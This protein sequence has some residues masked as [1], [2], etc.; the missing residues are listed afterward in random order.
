MHLSPDQVIYW[1]HGFFK[2]NSTILT[3]WVLMLLLTVAALL[4]T[5]G[6]STGLEISRWQNFLEIIVG[7]IRDQIG[8]V[9]LPR[10]ERS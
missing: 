6:L 7:G 2:L 9:G 10:P 5:R 8:E 1:Q 3:T 4:M